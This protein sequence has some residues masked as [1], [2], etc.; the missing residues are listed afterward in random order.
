MNTYVTGAT[1]KQLRESRNM[2]QADLA[3]QIGVSSKTVSKWETA[4][5]LPDMVL[6][7]TPSRSARSDWVSL[8]AS[9]RVLIVLPVT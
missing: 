4:R 7:L 9:R 2:T 5:G 1:I 3:E 6:L 8:L